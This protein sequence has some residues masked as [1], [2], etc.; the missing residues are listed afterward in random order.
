M[1]AATPTTPFL[2]VIA[3]AIVAAA[4]DDVNVGLFTG[5]PTLS[6]STVLGDLTPPTFTGYAKVNVA[7]GTRRSNA[8]GDLI[9][10]IPAAS[11][12]PSNNTDLP[13]TVTGISIDMED[14]GGDVLWLAELLEEPWEVVT[15]GSALDVICEIYVRA[16]PQYGGY[17][18]TCSV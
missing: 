10:P 15:S 16:D 12:Q 6:P 7:F 13:Q 4:P 8:N 11:F 17:C 2:D 5:N 3:D 14:A 1:L 9:L 18:T